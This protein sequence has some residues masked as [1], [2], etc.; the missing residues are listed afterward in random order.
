[1]TTARCFI[2]TFHLIREDRKQWFKRLLPF[3][4]IL[5]TVMTLVEIAWHVF[6]IKVLLPTEILLQAGYPQEAIAEIISD[7]SVM[8][9]GISFATILCLL[10]QILFVGVSS[11]QIS[12]WSKNQSVT[13]SFEEPQPHISTFTPIGF[14]PKKWCKS[15]LHGLFLVLKQP[16]KFIDVLI[17]SILLLLVTS[18]VLQLPTIVLIVSSQTA[19]ISGMM[20]D[21]ITTPSIVWIAMV[22]TTLFANTILFYILNFCC[23]CIAFKKK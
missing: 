19:T 10:L 23:W 13:K 17:I 5:S 21:Q 3:V 12:D 9:I 20:F 11:Q 1:M 8:L 2:E 18:I 22:L 15:F 4:V 14:A 16:T 6:D 7:S